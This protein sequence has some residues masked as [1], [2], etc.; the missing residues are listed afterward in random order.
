MLSIAPAGLQDA[1]TI[2]GMALEIWR[3]H[4]LPDVLNQDEIDYFWNRM[5]RPEAIRNE[6]ECGIVYERILRQG[7]MVGFL[8]YHHQPEQA[9]MRLNKLYLLPQ[10]HGRGYGALALAHVK[11][12]AARLGAREIYLYVFRKNNT[13]VR[14]YLRA[15]FVI[16]RAEVTECGDGYYY[17]DYVMCYRLDEAD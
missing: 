16:V 3:R 6:M 5:Y 12:V 15:G 1:E 8:A 2:A 9:R 11:A 13:A 17:D 14:A 10:Y 4:Y 7:E